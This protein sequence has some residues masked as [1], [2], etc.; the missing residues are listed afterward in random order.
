MKLQDRDGKDIKELIWI[1]TAPDGTTDYQSKKPALHER[2]YL[3]YEYHGD[4]AQLW[5]VVEKVGTGTEIMRYNIRNVDSID[6]A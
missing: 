5:A 3:S 6:W 2:I 4:H 1:C